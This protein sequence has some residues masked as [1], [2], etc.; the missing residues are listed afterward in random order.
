[1]CGLPFRRGLTDFCPKM[2]FVGPIWACFGPGSGPDQ[3]RPKITKNRVWQLEDG[4]GRGPL[5]MDRIHLGNVWP[6]VSSCFDHLL[7]PKGVRWPNLGLFGPGLPAAVRNPKLSV[8]Q[9]RHIES[10]SRGHFSP[11]PTPTFGGFHLSQLPKCTARRGFGLLGARLA[12]FRGVL[13]RQ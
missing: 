11:V 8:S 3:K 5:F 6:A 10:R 2:V 13:A 12:A 9:A 4:R 1:M 7:P